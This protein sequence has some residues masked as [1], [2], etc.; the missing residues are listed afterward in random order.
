MEYEDRFSDLEYDDE[1]EFEDDTVTGCGEDEYL[2]DYIA[3]NDYFDDY[4][5]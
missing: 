2:D 5:F 3:D 1:Y 4:D